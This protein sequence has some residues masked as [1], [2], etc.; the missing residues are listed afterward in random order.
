[1]SQPPKDPGCPI[2]DENGEV[3]VDE[4]GNVRVSDEVMKRRHPVV[5]NQNGSI[6]NDFLSINVR[7]ITVIA[8]FVAALATIVGTTYGAVVFVAAP[9]MR[10]EIR[11]LDAPLADRIALEE[12]RMTMHELQVAE[13]SLGYMTRDEVQ[14]EV[15]HLQ[16]EI[17]GLRERIDRTR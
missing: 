1:M 15:T 14:R 17:A 6:R 12:K 10:E 3:R 8:A 2:F 9:R 7:T 11:L 16:I 4:N 5:Y 13:K